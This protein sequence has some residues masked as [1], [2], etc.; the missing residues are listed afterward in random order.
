[1]VRS[2]EYALQQ[3]VYNKLRANTALM[4]ALAA[5]KGGL[6]D[7]VPDKTKYPRVVIGEGTLI[8]WDTE[9]DFGAEQTLTIHV[10]SDQPGMKET[11]M[12]MG[13][14]YQ[15]LHEVAITPV[16]FNSVFIRREFSTTML[17]ADGATRHGVLRFRSIMG[18]VI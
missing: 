1:M 12:I 14:V 4:D 2:R 8:D 5:R 17:D 10:W 15:A 13:L 7:N 3:A 16:G 6:F 9:S 11:K 18:E